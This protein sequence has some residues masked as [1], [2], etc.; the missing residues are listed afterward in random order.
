MTVSSFIFIFLSLYVNDCNAM[1]LRTASKAIIKRCRT[2]PIMTCYLVT[3][4]NNFGVNKN[5]ALLQC[6]CNQCASDGQ[7]NC[8]VIR[9]LIRKVLPLCQSCAQPPVTSTWQLRIARLKKICGFVH[10]MTRAQLFL[11]SSAYVVLRAPQYA[12]PLRQWY[13]WIACKGV[14]TFTRPLDAAAVPSIGWVQVQ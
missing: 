9:Q 10:Y 11:L 4:V 3:N 6:N 8:H 2:R 5:R 14:I 1:K 12:L 7:S 13:L